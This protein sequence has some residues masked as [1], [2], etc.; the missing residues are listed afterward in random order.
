MFNRI[1]IQAGSNQLCN[2]LNIQ[3]LVDMM[4]YYKEVHIVVSYI[5]LKQLLASFGE[6]ILYQLIKDR[7]LFLHI[8]DE[9][10]GVTKNNDNLVM[11]DM[12]HNK[13]INSKLQ[14]MMS[15]YF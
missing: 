10:I 9:H 5:E 11:I 1:I 2:G 4:F 7:M 8:C 13:S 6:D 12:F 3:G 15:N 14:G